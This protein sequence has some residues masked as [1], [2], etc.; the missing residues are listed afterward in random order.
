[1]IFKWRNFVTGEKTPLVVGGTRT[2]ILADSLHHT[3]TL[4]WWWEQLFEVLDCQCVYFMFSTK[5]NNTHD[6]Y[7]T[8]NLYNLLKIKN[9]DK[10]KSFFYHKVR[11]V[12]NTKISDYTPWWLYQF[13][14]S[15]LYHPEYMYSNTG[16]SCIALQMIIS[17]TLS[18]T[19]QLLNII[20]KCKY[21]NK[22][23]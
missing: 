15:T 3:Y 4:V 11:I 14:K 19:V 10:G 8:S 12:C 18:E 20:N 6:Q 2:Q 13:V 22:C 23:K 1:M 5:V 21:I 7:S 16:Y 9:R 17:T